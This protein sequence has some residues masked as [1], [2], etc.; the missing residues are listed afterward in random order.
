M[1]DMHSLDGLVAVE[2]TPPI[3]SR[4]ISSSSTALRLAWPWQHCI[5]PCDA[6]SYGCNALPFVECRQNAFRN[7]CFRLSVMEP[8]GQPARSPDCLP[9]RARAKASHAA[10]PCLVL[11]IPRLPRAAL[12]ALPHT[13]SSGFCASEKWSEVARKVRPSEAESSK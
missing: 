11:P 13:A 5:S 4:D 2:P 8:V 7:N 9:T 3:L 10:S 6:L 1:A 12:T